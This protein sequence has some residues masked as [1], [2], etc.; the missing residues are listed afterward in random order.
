MSILPKQCPICA[1]WIQGLLPQNN[2]AV[3]IQKYDY[4]LLEKFLSWL[5][6]SDFA[7]HHHFGEQEKNWNMSHMWDLR[8]ATP[9]IDAFLTEKGAKKSD[10]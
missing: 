10:K 8:T 9:L 6:D 7:L 2:L 5:Y 3:G 4:V 1:A